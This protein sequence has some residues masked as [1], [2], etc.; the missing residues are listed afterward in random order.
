MSSY[1]K[2]NFI[3]PLKEPKTKPGQIC[4]VCSGLIVDDSNKP[5]DEEVVKCFCLL[6]I[7]EE[8]HL[9]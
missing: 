5:L 1:T 6:K 2:Y 4:E 9:C 8:F 7:L 3:P